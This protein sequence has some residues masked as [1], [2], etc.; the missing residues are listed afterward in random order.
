M[1][2]QQAQTITIET[3]EQLVADASRGWSGIDWDTDPRN[4]L[5]A[6]QCGENA[7]RAF[8][9]HECGAGS[10]FGSDGSYESQQAQARWGRALEMEWSAELLSELIALV[11]VENSRVADAAEAA[12]EHGQEIIAALKSRPA[13]LD[14]ASAAA[15]RAVNLEMEYGDDPCW[16]PV[17]DAVEQLIATEADNAN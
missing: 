9:A 10:W 11:D 15:T 16:G 17:R 8:C 4:A 5:H 3:I 2:A 7:W 13:D 1:E 6:A 14:E 12:V